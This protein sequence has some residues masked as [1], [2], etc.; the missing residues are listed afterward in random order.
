MPSARCKRAWARPKKDHFDVTNTVK[1]AAECKQTSND[2]ER[3]EER[4]NDLTEANWHI[5]SQWIAEFRDKP[6]LVLDNTVRDH[7]VNYASHGWHVFPV[8]LGTKMSHKSAEHSNGRPWGT[9]TDAAEIRRDFK[10]WP[11][12]NAGVVTG[13]VSGIFVVEADT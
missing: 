4:M 5:I 8:P 6:R 10:R 13:A 9:T 3:E 2:Y 1:P 7:G 12:A 11:D